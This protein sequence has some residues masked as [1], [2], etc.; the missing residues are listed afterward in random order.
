MKLRKGHSARR[1]WALGLSAAA[2]TGTVLSGTMAAAAYAAPTQPAASGQAAAGGYTPASRTLKMGMHGADVKRLQQRL[3]QLGYY[4]GSTDGHFG[5]DTEEAVW[6]FQEVQNLHASGE[7]TWPVE[8]KLV[9]PSTPKALVPR[10][11][12]TRVEISLG[13]HVLYV[14]HKNRVILISHISSGGGYYYCDGGCSRAITPTGN[15]HTTWRVHGWHT[16]PLGQMYNPVFFYEGYAVHGDTYVPL[17]PV[18]HGCV[19][20]PMD[21]AN[22]Y[23]GL[24]PREG[25]PVYVRAKG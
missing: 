10:G 22:I 16:S 8:K 9:Y 24:V 17:N 13:R 20:V 5:M 21:V 7:I 14:Y 12:S 4:P 2:V 25:I 19:R 23:P 1:R 18:S 15:F 3:E 6:A 11:G